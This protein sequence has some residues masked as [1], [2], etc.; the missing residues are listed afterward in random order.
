[1]DKKNNY[2]FGHECS[3]YQGCSGGC[4][5]VRNNNRVIGIHQG[6]HK[7]NSVNVGIFINDVIEDIKNKVNHC[8]Y[9]LL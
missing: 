8:S 9:N 3:T 6:G 2:F 5:V 1:M 4:I 7:K